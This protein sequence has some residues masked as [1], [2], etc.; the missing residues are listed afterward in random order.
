MADLD[1][2]CPKCHELGCHYWRQLKR[3]KPLTD[4]KKLP[5]HEDTLL[6]LD[7]AVSVDEQLQVLDDTMCQSL[8]YQMSSTLGVFQDAMERYLQIESADY[9]AKELARLTAKHA[10][11]RSLHCVSC[12]ERNMVAA[13]L[14]YQQE[15]TR[16]VEEKYPHTSQKP[17]VGSAASSSENPE[18]GGTG[19]E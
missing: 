13:Q 3:H 2:A 8:D 6:R 10:Q 19:V 18:A 14:R 17:Q 7:N 5:E 4:D 12:A 11:C 15:L 16:W 1:R 9:L